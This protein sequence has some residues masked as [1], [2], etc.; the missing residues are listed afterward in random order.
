MGSIEYL[1]PCHKEVIILLDKQ[2]KAFAEKF[3]DKF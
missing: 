3:M 1:Q 2:V